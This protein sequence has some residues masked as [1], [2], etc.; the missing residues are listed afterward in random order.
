MALPRIEDAR[1][2]DNGPVAR[3]QDSL[4]TSSAAEANVFIKKADVYLVPLHEIAEISEEDWFFEFVALVS[5]I[6]L[7]VIIQLLIDGPSAE[8]LVYIWLLGPF[9]LILL[10][11]HVVRLFNKTRR[12]N[13]LKDKAIPG[14]I[15]TAHAFT[16][17]AVT[18]DKS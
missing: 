12:I 16:T 9:F 2:A 5:G 15:N 11:Y 6:V 8:A 14:T 7:G 17:G 1:V 10:G 4:V 18:E 13:S 3:S